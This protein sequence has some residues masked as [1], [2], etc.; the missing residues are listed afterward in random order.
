MSEESR[1]IFANGNLAALG[2]CFYNK[3]DNLGDCI[4]QC[5]LLM[6]EEKKRM[7]KEYEQ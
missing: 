1:K 4:E 6:Y 5:D 3:I 2:Y 7:K